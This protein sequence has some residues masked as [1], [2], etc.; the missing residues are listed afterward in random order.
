VK[1]TNEEFE[2]HLVSLLYLCVAPTLHCLAYYYLS[3]PPATVLS[4]LCLLKSPDSLPGE[5]CLVASLATAIR[6]NSVHLD[7][8]FMISGN[9]LPLAESSLILLLVCIYCFVYKNGLK[10]AQFSRYIQASDGF[11]EI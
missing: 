7:S 10:G 8:K 1:W 3:S 4:S 9:L 6:Q 2:M 11:P 5:S